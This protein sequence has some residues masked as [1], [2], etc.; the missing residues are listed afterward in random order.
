MKTLVTAILLLASFGAWSQE[1]K[2]KTVVI[3]TSAECNECEL[4]LEEEMNYTKGVVFAELDVKS[5]DLTVKYNTK[6]IDEAKIKEIIAKL[7]YDADDVKA[8]PKAQGKLPECCQPG[9]M[10]R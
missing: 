10:H 4:R 8:D 7:G 2:T 5:Q 6:K 9:G 3:H 1:E